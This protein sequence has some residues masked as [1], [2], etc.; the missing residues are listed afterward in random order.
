MRLLLLPILVLLLATFAPA[1]LHQ[2]PGI[3]SHPEVRFTPILLNEKRP[4]EH[5]LGQLEYLGGWSLSSNDPH[6][7]GISAIHVREGQAIAVSDS[8]SLIRFALPATDGGIEKLSLVR[9]RQGPGPSGRKRNRDAEGMVIDAGE[10]WISFEHR[11]A[12]WRYD[13]DDWHARAGTAPKVL[14]GWNRKTGGEAII[15]MPDGRFLV[16]AEGPRA[17][18]GSTEVILFDRDPTASGVRTLQLRY[19]APIGYRVTDAALLGGGRLLFLNR[20]FS[21]TGGFSVKLTLGTLPKLSRGALLTGEEI[22][23][24]EPPFVNEN[25]EALSV[26]PK[27]QGG[28]IVWIA[29]DDNFSPLQRTLLLKFELAKR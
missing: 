5:H 28:H 9:L 10:A 24:F 26:M 8:G 18:D 14:A 27:A 21:L 17:P 23:S 7:G 22:A 4:T 20:R 25:F 11:N 29:S 16:F 2:P 13:P 19:Q 6:F 15:R 1:G 12:V 3:P